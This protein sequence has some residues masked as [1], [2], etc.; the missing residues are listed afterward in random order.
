MLEL[1]E[2]LIEVVLL[3]LSEE[4]LDGLIVAGE[5]LFVEWEEAEAEMGEDFVVGA[6]FDFEDVAPI[7]LAWEDVLCE[8]AAESGLVAV[9]ECCDLSRGEGEDHAEAR[10]LDDDV[11]V[12]FASSVGDVLVLECFAEDAC[13]VAVVGFED[14]GH[15]V[16][17]GLEDE[18]EAAVVADGLAEGGGG[19]VGRDEKR[20]EGGL[21]GAWGVGALGLVERLPSGEVV[22]VLLEIAEIGLPDDVFDGKDEV[23][24]SDDVAFARGCRCGDEEVASWVD[25]AAV[26]EAEVVGRGSREGVDGGENHEVAGVGVFLGGAGDL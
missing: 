18:A 24:A 22:V 19:A 16:A 6:V 5:E 26:V 25:F 9:D 13:V 1:R 3:G 7:E 8:S 21:H 11:F 10:G 23:A 12:F 14:V 17:F 2:E 20:A 4:E 15:G